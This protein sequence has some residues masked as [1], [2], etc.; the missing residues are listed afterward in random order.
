[1][2]IT[3][4]RVVTSL[5]HQ[6]IPEDVNLLFF[7]IFMETPTGNR[8]QLLRQYRYPTPFPSLVLLLLVTQT[9]HNLVLAQLQQPSSL[10]VSASTL[11]ASPTDVDL[12]LASPTNSDTSSIS[13]LAPTV[14][15]ATDH[16]NYTASTK[17]DGTSDKG[18]LNYY[19]LFILVFVIII[20]L[21]YWSIARRRKQR[22][23]N[24]RNHQ[25]SALARDV[26]SW[27]GRGNR[28]GGRWRIMGAEVDPRAEEGL[29]ERGE[30]PPPYLKEPEPAHNDGRAGLEMH[31]MGR[32]EGKLPEYEAGPSGR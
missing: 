1:M 25:Q 6:H 21:V 11:P 26:D 30:A 8:A 14:L 10:A 31:D 28:L 22:I 23:A 15:S 29:D 18:I 13:D 20:F 3:P 17:D 12:L 7:F 24:L 5:F 4:I 9:W 2:F 16:A 32:D 19:F 27:P